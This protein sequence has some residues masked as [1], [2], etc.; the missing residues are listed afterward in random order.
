MT[1]GLIWRMAVLGVP[2]AAL[3]GCGGL[4]DASYVLDRGN[5]NYDAL[6]TATEACRAKGGEIRLRPNYAGQDLSDY[7]CAIGKAR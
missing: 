4:T 5:A 7:E 6:K 1:E 2:A 3:S